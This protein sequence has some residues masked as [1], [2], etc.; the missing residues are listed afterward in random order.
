MDDHTVQ[1]TDGVATLASPTVV[2]STN[3]HAVASPTTSLIRDGGDEY[4]DG[5][6]GGGG[7]GEDGAVV[8]FDDDYDKYEARKCWRLRSYCK[9]TTMAISLSFVT[10]MMGVSLFIFSANRNR[11]VVEVVPGP[12]GPLFDRNATNT[13]WLRL[14]N[15]LLP[16]HEVVI[17]G[18]PVWKA[19]QWM[20]IKDPLRPIPSGWQVS[21]RY[22]LAVAF[23]SWSGESGWALVQ[24]DGWIQSKVGLTG[25]VEH[26]CEWT[27]VGCNSEKKVTSITLGNID[28]DKSTFA[29]YGQIPSELGLLMSLETLDLSGHFLKGVLPIELVSLAPTLKHLYVSAN[30][31]TGFNGKLMGKLTSLE[32]LYLDKNLLQGTLPTTLVNLS[33]LRVLDVSSNQNLTGKALVMMKSWPNLEEFDISRTGIGGTIPDEIGELSNLKFLGMEY[34]A[35][36]CL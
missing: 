28:D 26:E 34:T 36:S 24:E 9:A 15:E 17:P 20:T 23:Y 35:V 7:D 22:A 21:Q 3:N 13:Y 31:L 16:P 5:D 33:R 1:D 4:G 8:T 10:L 27:G 18:S 2:V 29:L 30:R 25:L 19:L 6:G 12:P 32:T 11:V 14:T